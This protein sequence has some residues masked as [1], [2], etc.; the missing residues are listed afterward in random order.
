VGGA[1]EDPV[2]RL[3]RVSFRY[4]DGI[5]ALEDV[6]F[7]VARGEAV[8]LLGANGCGKST[9]LRLLDGLAAP[10]AGE[11]QA[12]GRPLVPATLEDRAFSREFRRR[13]GLLFQDPDVQ[14][15][16]ATV[17][18][19]VAFGPLE[20]GLAPEEVEAR[21]AEALAFLGIER[22]AGRSPVSLSGGE[23]KKVALAALLVTDPAVLLLDEPFAALD[24]RSQAW[25]MEVLL[26][27]R[28]RGKTVIAATHDLSFAEDLA[29]RAIVL[30][31]DHRVA[32]DGR[33]E[34]ALGDEA[35]LLRVNLIHAHVHRHGKL[36]HAHPHGH[37]HGHGHGHDHGGGQG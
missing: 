24:P 23:K 5:A 25:L 4:P 1:A 10:A 8:S 3:E 35:L 12:F 22:L 11:V 19:E 32:F 31:E 30:G 17:R 15:F 36:V 7:S 21:V 34:A 2:F 6:S 29:E 14:L 37:G 27:L 28:T 13:V 26:E 33:A 16:S 18:D 9:L 20:L